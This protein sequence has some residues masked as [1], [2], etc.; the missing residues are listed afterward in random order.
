MRLK[1][2]LVEGGAAVHA[3]FLEAGLADALEVVIA[4]MLIGGRGA[5]S[6]IAGSGVARLSDAVRLTDVESR[7]LGEDILVRAR[8]ARSR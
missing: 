1:N 7:R 6:P 5:P 2:L 4:P 3:G 8:T